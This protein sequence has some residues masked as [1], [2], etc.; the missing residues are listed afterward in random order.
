[1]AARIIASLCLEHE[2]V[3]LHPDGKRRSAAVFNGDAISEHHPPVG[4]E[5]V[6]PLASLGSEQ[7]KEKY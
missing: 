1:M 4:H 3:V 2:P 6:N 5:G 7:S